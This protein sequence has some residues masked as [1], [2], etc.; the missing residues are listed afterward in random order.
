[1][2]PALG[3]GA[4]APAGAAGGAPGRALTRAGS[5]SCT[6]ASDQNSTSRSPTGAIVVVAPPSRWP[7]GAR[8]QR[9]CRAGRRPPRPRRT[10][11]TRRRARAA[12]RGCSSRAPSA[13]AR[14]R[15]AR[16]RG[17]CCRRASRTPRRRARTPRACSCARRR[18]AGAR[19]ARAL[20]A[21][22]S[23]RA[24]S[25]YA[26]RRG[27]SSL[28][29]GSPR[30]T[31]VARTSPL[32]AQSSRRPARRIASASARII[33]R[34]A[35]SPSTPST[36]HTARGGAP[37]ARARRRRAARARPRRRPRAR[38][39]RAPRPPRAGSASSA[40]G[41]VGAQRRGV[42][43]ARN[44][45]PRT[46]AGLPARAIGPPFGWP[47]ADGRLAAGGSRPAERRSH[48]QRVGGVTRDAVHR[49]VLM[50]KYLGQVRQFLALVD[51]IRLVHCQTLS[52]SRACQD[53][54]VST[55]SSC[56]VVT[57][58][59]PLRSWLSDGCQTRQA[60]H[61]RSR[62]RQDRLGF[63][64]VA[65]AVPRQDRDERGHCGGETR[66][67]VESNWNVRAALIPPTR[68]LATGVRRHR[69]RRPSRSAAR[70]AR[71]SARWSSIRARRWPR[72]PS[73][74]A[75]LGGAACPT[76]RSIRQAARA[77]PALEESPC[78]FEK[79]DSA[80][81]TRDVSCCDSRE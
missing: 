16:R 67:R 31:C 60:C 71:P 23:A 21:A 51:V 17:R 50:T 9:S 39:R 76:S 6:S 11:G 69:A 43:P 8:R 12:S 35:A 55:L 58:K 79:E 4:A 66:A 47:R 45:Q 72:A 49:R 26:V 32:L 22:P 77:P 68:S 73:R 18:R 28:S 15:A 48:R 10:R 34:H 3:G 27:Q 2:P 36:T 80:R 1:M 64:S 33:A 42:W 56:R 62:G 41:A 29:P 14:R 38:R 70:A 44:T 24:T 25:V 54:S 74:R 59:G 75:S 20:T 65:V 78:G 7:A 57:T 40:A 46:A 13:C 63:R 81:P 30:H 19:H 53:L 52:R 5:T 61:H 37:R